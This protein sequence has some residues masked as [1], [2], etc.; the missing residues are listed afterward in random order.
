MRR[1]ANKRHLLEC[2]SPK[3]GRQLKKVGLVAD[4]D[5]ARVKSMLA[6]G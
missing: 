4:A 5:V 2:K 1:H 6:G 3:R